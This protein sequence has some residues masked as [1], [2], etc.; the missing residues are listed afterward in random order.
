MKVASLS[1]WILLIAVMF[2]PMAV[3]LS[4]MVLPL[5]YVPP[6]ALF[7]SCSFVICSIAALLSVYVMS[8][9]QKRTMDENIGKVMSIT[10]MTS[11]IIAPIG[12]YAYGHLFKVFAQHAFAPIIL[13]CAA[14]ALLSI[15]TKHILK[16]EVE[17]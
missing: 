12:Q 2:V 3:A 17:A 7:I 15:A 9:I 10:I 5:G 1:K 4:P 6:Y 16:D 13:T 11:Q 14:M 8:N